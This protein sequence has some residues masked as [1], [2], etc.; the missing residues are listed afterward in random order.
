MKTIATAI[1]AAL[2]A[3]GAS[4]ANIYGGFG[5]NNPDLSVGYASAPMDV[6]GVQPGIGASFDRYHGWADNNPDLFRATGGSGSTHQPPDRY[7]SFD[8]GN[9]D[10]M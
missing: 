3:T 8:D 9:P 1:A 5:N 2:F 10:L 6:I 7:G 4:A